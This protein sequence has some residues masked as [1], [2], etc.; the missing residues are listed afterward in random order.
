M[1]LEEKAYLCLLE[2]IITNGDEQN[3]RTGVGTYSLFG[4]SLRFDLSN[5]TL[6]II[7]TRKLYYKAAIEELLFFIRGFTNTKLLEEKGVN[8][9]KGN[10]SREFL[11][12]R[13]LNY[14]EGEMG[15]MY[16]YLWRN[17]NGIDQLQNAFNL[18]KNNPSSRRIM[19]T[20]YDPSKSHLSVLDPCHVMYQFRVS[21]NE[22]SCLWFQRSADYCIGI[23]TNIISYALLTHLMAKA[24]GLKAKELIGFFGDTHV[25]KNHLTQAKEQLTREPY[26]FPTLNVKDI[27]SIQDMEM[28]SYNDFEIKGY[29]HHP[30]LKMA[31]AV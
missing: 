15:P 19:V 8:I 11:D 30:P 18:I 3:D 27:S 25:Y 17:Y 4:K 9:W 22:L 14:A 10:T 28:L 16:G 29:S 20:A 13:N 5:N 6:P 31:M 1:N 26:P 12:S 7:T 24:T 2:D 21:N 23:P